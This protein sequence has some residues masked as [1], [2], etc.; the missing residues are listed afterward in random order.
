[1]KKVST[2]ELIMS[3]LFVALITIGAFFKIPT[4]LVPISLQYTF[5]ML[6]GLLLGPKLGALS[7][8]AYMV[9]GL[10]GVPVFTGGG[11]PSYVLTPT[12][13][14][15]IGFVAG[16]YVTGCIAHKN[17][18]ITFK[19]L[20]FANFAGMLVVYIFGIVY[21]VLVMSLYMNYDV[22]PGFVMVNLFLVFLP[23]D[24]LSCV[25]GAFLGQKLI[26]Q[27][28]KMQKQMS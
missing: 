17:K 21:F 2:F 24:T 4:P 5:T 20:L 14:Y 15:I 28:N 7:C 27:I 3:A 13:G 8:F 6:A 1:M 9:L 16:T 22:T 11:G 18:N 19:R 25:I 23:A 26:P 10:V 12:F